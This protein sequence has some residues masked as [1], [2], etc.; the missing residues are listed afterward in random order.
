MK[1]AIYA[2]VS[3]A[4]QSYAM[5]LSEVCEYARRN[6]WE[7]IEYPEKMSTRKQRPVHARLMEDARLK[8]FDIVLVWKLDRFGR[9]VRDLTENIIKLDNYGVRFIALTSGIDTDKRNPT[10][11]LLLHVMA[12]F[13]EFER[14]LIRERVVSGVKQYQ[15]D[16]AAGKAQSHTGKNQRVGRPGKVFDR[17]QAAAARKAGASYRAIADQFSLSV[18][19]AFKALR[20]VDAENA[21][22]GP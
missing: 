1:V 19:A 15:T 9:S 16:F 18:G 3:T 13:A 20:D 7:I 22:G 11:K 10:N 12:A 17:A 8:K 6:D 14:D 4:D 21:A 5:Q 2:R